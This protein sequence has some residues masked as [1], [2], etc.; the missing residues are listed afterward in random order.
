MLILRPGEYRSR[1]EQ[2]RDRTADSD[3][4]QAVARVIEGAGDHLLVRTPGTE[5]AEVACRAL[6]GAELSPP[7]A[8]AFVNGFGLTTR[9]AQRLRDLLRGSPTIR[10]ISS[11]TL[12]P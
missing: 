6:E 5:M 12:P 11:H 2:Q 10:V 7:V 3:R 1:W 8:D 4:Y 9:Q